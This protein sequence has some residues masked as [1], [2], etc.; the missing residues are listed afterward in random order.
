MFTF[1]KLALVGTACLA[2]FAISC[3][4]DDGGDDAVAG[5]GGSV[6]GFGAAMHASIS[7]SITL[8]GDITA[9]AGNQIEAISITIGKINGEGKKPDEITGMPS[10][11]QDKVSLTGKY[12]A[13]PGSI[14]EVGSQYLLVLGVSFT[15]G[16][17]IVAQ[18]NITAT[19]C[20]NDVSLIKKEIMLGYDSPKKSYAD[21]DGQ[22]ALYSAT[23]VATAITAAKIDLIAYKGS[24]AKDSIYTPTG[25]NLTNGSRLVEF[26][27]LTDTDAATI[28]NATVLSQIA[29]FASKL[30]EI[31]GYNPDTEEDENA[32]TMV[33]ANKKG[34][35]VFTSEGDYVAVVH[36]AD[37]PGTGTGTAKLTVTLGTIGGFAQ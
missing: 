33:P 23:D 13:I 16:L 4:D 19:S 3:S 31:T 34:F 14:C 12:F 9:T 20:P 10:L 37:G 28:A 32:V 17:P 5:D 36:K 22:T 2:A 27:P 15:T 21:I 25:A 18:V 30:N 26:Y 29:S 8:S 7:G 6:T 24:N 11:P 1:K 35:L